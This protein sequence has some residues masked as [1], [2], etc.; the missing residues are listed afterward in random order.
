[1]FCGEWSLVK[2]LQPDLAVRPLPCRCWT[3]EECRPAR[4][5]R[6]VAEAK[7]GQPNRF[8]TLTSRYRPNGSPDAAARALV[9]A[10]RQVRA[11]YIRR[12]GPRSLPFI[13]VFEATKLGWPHLHILARA[14]WIDQRWLSKR[15]AALTGA[16]IVD[17]RRVK[18]LA[19]VAAYV[20]KYIGKNPHRFQ[21]VKRYWRSLD[22][23]LP[24]PSQDL[25]H[26]RDPEPWM[27]VRQHW[28]SYVKETLLLGFQADF[29]QNGAT[30][31]YRTPP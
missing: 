8:I 17:V 15:M 14:G 13:A 24:D 4:A 29:A 11:E 27:V 9:K 25:G 2:R 1:M 31:T 22:Y 30:L 3:C 23:L 7:T 12:H 10:W 21:G 20:S 18:G 26:D 6:L 16:P 5:A 19:K 28:L